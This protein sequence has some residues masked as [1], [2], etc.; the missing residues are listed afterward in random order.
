MSGFKDWVEARWYGDP[1][2]L[3][4]LLPLSKLFAYCAAQRRKKLHIQAKPFAVPVVVIGN[5]AVGGTG[6]TPT[7]ITLV[8]FLQA[9]GVRVGVVSRGY[10]RVQSK[11]VLPVIAHDSSTPEQLGD[12]PY[13]IYR[14]TRCPLAVSADRVAAVNTLIST[15]Q[16]ELILSDD[17][18]QHYSM[19]RDK[20]I[21]VVDAQ[22]QCGN[23]HMM[24]VGPLREPP[25]RLQE[26]D[27]VLYSCA[28]WDTPVPQNAFAIHVQPLCFV[29][30]LSGDEI[31]LDQWSALS[32]GKNCV[33]MAGLGNPQKFFTT[34]EQL[35]LIFD[36]RPMPDHHAYTEDDFVGLDNSVIVMTEKDA[37]KCKH[38]VNKNAYYVKIAMALPEEFLNEFLQ[39]VRLVRH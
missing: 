3:K 38:L 6:K 21:A 2:A 37:V 29:N 25:T 27:W 9:Q 13:M 32:A 24:P 39:S 28:T 36:A 5:I 17:G 20:E 30:V 19:F 18:L 22:R 16:C 1:G 23:G 35:Q 7:I 14:A 12:E 33:A 10:G 15:A 31:A 26:V 34:L 4:I 11:N 8:Q